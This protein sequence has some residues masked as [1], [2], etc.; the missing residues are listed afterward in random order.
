LE[1]GDIS[2]FGGIEI[3]VFEELI[4]TVVSIGS[5]FLT[6]LSINDNVLFC[7]V[8]VLIL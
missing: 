1:R 4:A 7:F 8:F 5:G 6:F 2:R 3:L